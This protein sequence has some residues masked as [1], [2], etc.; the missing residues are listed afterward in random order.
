MPR[1]P[2]RPSQLVR[3]ARF[4]T[5]GGGV[6]QFNGN[7]GL[8]Y[9]LHHRMPRLLQELHR[10]PELQSKRCFIPSHTYT[11][12]LA[13]KS[14]PLTALKMA[15]ST[16]RTVSPSTNKVV[17]EVPETTVDEARSIAR[18]SQDAFAEY[19]LMP[20]QQ[21]KEI[22]VRALKTIQERKM[23]LG[24]ELTEQMGRP[25]AFSHKEIET[26]QKRADYLLETAEE[27]LKSI[28]GKP[29]AGFQ[30]WVKKVP[31]GPVLVVFAWNVSFPHTL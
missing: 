5:V 30:R 1:G 16:I 15:N 14:L 21:R 11:T 18:A 19:R 31:I 6:H 25:I 7:G 9:N 24:K 27:A 3:P 26:M 28:P 13:T 29:E 4:R 2:E 10:L 23:D 22:V 20:F 12:S 8:W 17:C